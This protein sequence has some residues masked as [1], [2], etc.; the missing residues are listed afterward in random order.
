MKDVMKVMMR[1]G[2]SVVARDAT[3]TWPKTHQRRYQRRDY[4]GIARICTWRCDEGCDEKRY[5]RLDQRRYARA[6]DS[7]VTT[8]MTRVAKRGVGTP[9]AARHV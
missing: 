7:C 5:D 8:D 4:R 6:D 2:T 9:G 1:D 3:K